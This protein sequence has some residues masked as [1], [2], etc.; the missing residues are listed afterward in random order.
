MMLKRYL[1][2][3]LLLLISLGCPS[4]PGP[5]PVVLGPLAQKAKVF[6][7]DMQKR[8]VLD[9]QALCKLKR[10]TTATP[11]ITYNMP[12]DAYMTGIHLGMLAMRYA[13]TG[14]AT[15]RREAGESIQA[16]DL[17]CTVSGIKGLLARSAV[18][19][20]TPF[21][22][23]GEWH[24]TSDGTYLWRGDVSTDQMVGGDVRV[25]SGL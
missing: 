17:L 18:P 5:E 11:D 13:V 20:D 9:G 23:D 4:Q 2:A 25:L 3:V 16:L 15:T 24:L 12:D 21:S 1:G 19:I 22:D 8:F 7:Y 14:D 10:P 6:D